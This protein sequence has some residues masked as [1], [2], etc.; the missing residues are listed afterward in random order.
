MLEKIP[1]VVG[2]G[3]TGQSII[4]YLSESYKELFVIEEWRE[5]PYIE[6]LKK[7]EINFHINPQINNELSHKISEIYISPGIAKEHEIF[8]Y[9]KTH[10]I[11]VSSDI[12]KF[13]NTNESIKV[14]VSGTNGKTS[15]CL[16]IESLFRLV[17]PDLRISVLGNIGKPVLSCIKDDIDIAIIEVSSFQLELL[18]EIQFD[19]GLLLNIEQDH[20]DMHSSYEDYQKIKYS[21]LEKARFNI[22][23]DRKYALFKDSYTYRDIEMPRELID[24]KAFNDWPLHDIENF[25]ASFAVLKCYCENFHKISFKEMNVS[26]ELEKFFLE[27]KKP[28]H[29]FELVSNSKGLNFI[30]DSKATNL[31][32]MLKAIKATRRLKKSGDIYLIC[33]GDLKGQKISSINITTVEDVDKAF[34]YGQD[35]E[36]LSKMMG[37]YTDCQLTDN[38]EEAFKKS[39]DLAGEDDCILLSPGCS[40]LDMFSNYQERGDKFR[41]LISDLQDE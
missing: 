41:S 33:G 18:D 37:S 19:I 17:F 7:S 40:S 39:T 32:A 26:A 25:R 31:D 4:K 28:P 5:N 30:N 12:E 35:K 3:V 34:I 15:T 1:L 38:L 29:R 27:F 13:V 8:S 24:S 9:A 36:I 23:F 21:I 6:E 20:M 14:L 22:S 16:M 10:K 11:K 2:L